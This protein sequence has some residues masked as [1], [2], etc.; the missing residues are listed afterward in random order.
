ML[1]FHRLHTFVWHGTDPGNKTRKIPG[2]LKFTKLRVIPDQFYLNIDDV[3]II[4]G[5]NFGDE[6]PNEQV[7]TKDDALITVKQM[8]FFELRDIEIMLNQTA[9]PIA[10]FIKFV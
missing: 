1:L 9:D 8:V 4:F 2:A 10:D 3:S 7:R 5:N 6:L